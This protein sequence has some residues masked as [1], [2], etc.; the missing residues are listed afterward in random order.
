MP[1]DLPAVKC[2][3][4]VQKTR[5]IGA[6]VYAVT[7]PG[8]AARAEEAAAFL[9]QPSLVVR[10][11]TKKGGEKDWDIAPFLSGVACRAEGKDLLFDMILPAGSEQNLNPALILTAWEG[12]G[13]L[14]PAVR[15]LRTGV[16]DKAGR[17]F[18]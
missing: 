5:E 7:L 1:P 16:L 2:A 10:K 3:Y 15:I 4:P 18:A 14:P 11:H 8:E 13:T 6:A 17:P 12:E 9:A